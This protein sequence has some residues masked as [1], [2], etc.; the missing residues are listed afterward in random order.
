[1][2]EPKHM[3]WDKMFKQSP[4]RWIPIYNNNKV[5]VEVCD[6]ETG[7]MWYCVGENRWLYIQ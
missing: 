7:N 4:K 1:M 3:N 2:L 6:I 5:L